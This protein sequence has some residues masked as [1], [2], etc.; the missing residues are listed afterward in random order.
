MDRPTIPEPR[1]PSAAQTLQTAFLRLWHE[2]LYTEVNLPDT[3]R[4][5]CSVWAGEGVTRQMLTNWFAAW[6]A[7]PRLE[8]PAGL[9]RYIQTCAFN[10]NQP[11]RRRPGHQPWRDNS[12]AWNVEPGGHEPPWMGRDPGTGGW[13]S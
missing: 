5:Q 4:E 8:T 13:G 1:K 2:A 10:R 9:Y 12:D 6:A 11:H 7:K 3:W